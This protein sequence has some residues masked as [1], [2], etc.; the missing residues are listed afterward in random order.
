[1]DNIEIGKRIKQ[2]REEKDMSLQDVANLTGVARSTVQRYEAGRIDKIKLPVIESIARSLEVR[3]DWIIGKT[4]KKFPETESVPEILLYYKSLNTTGKNI[5]T[6]QVRLLTLDEK[7]TRNDSIILLK[8]DSENCTVNAAHRRT[9]IPESEI[10]PEMIQA[11]ED[12]MKN[13]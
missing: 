2:S 9:D 6:E 11:D 12:I 3:P 7:Y 1:M 10:T 8:S 4:D 5:A 13:F